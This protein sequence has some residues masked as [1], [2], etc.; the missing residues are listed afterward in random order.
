[1]KGGLD[2]KGEVE[3]EEYGRKEER[4]NNIQLSSTTNIH[5]SPLC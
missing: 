3:K 4:R 5:P 2:G 1:M